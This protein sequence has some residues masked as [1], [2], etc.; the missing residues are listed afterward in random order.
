MPGILDHGL[1]GLALLVSMGYAVIRLG[2]KSVRRHLSSALGRLA[3][4]VPPAWGL[5]RAA[6]RLAMGAAGKGGGGC[7]GCESCGSEQPA[8]LQPG[9]EQSTPQAPAALQRATRQPAMQQGMTQQS[10]QQGMTQQSTQ[11]A[12]LQPRVTQ[13]QREIRIPVEHISRRTRG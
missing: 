6:E 12:A 5:G 13:Q 1:V 10:T 11:Q 8:A 2:P 7:S 3:A 4:F 9:V